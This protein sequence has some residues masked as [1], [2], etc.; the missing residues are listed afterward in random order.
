MKQRRVRFSAIAQQHVAREQAWWLEHRDHA[1]VFAEELKQAINVVAT[2]PGA[3]TPYAHSP[4]PGVRRIYLR[5][6]ALHLYYAFDDEEVIVYALSGAR[7][8]RGP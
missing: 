8:R 4:V 5:R 6:V 7:R 1:E 2:L 3:G